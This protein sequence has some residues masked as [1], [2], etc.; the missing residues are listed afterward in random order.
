MRTKADVRSSL[1]VHALVDL[2][3]HPARFQLIAPTDA[4]GSG[5]LLSSDAGDGVEV[6]GPPPTA[7]CSFTRD[8]ARPATTPAMVSR[9]VFK[10]PLTA[11]RCIL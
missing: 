6:H 3:I 8:L 1:R 7:Q 10:L 11:C 9:A 2:D 5:A 4:Q